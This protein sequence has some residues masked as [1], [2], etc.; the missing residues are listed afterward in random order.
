MGCSVR[1]IEWE[2]GEKYGHV[3]FPSSIIDLKE[4]IA[5]LDSWGVKNDYSF[6]IV[7]YFADK[8]LHLAF[9]VGNEQSY[10]EFMYDVDRS[11]NRGKGPYYLYNS[12]NKKG[13]TPI[14]YMASHAEVSLEKTMPKQDVLNAVY[15]FI[16]HCSFPPYIVLDDSEANEKFVDSNIDV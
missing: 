12:S 15:Y 4:K 11:T 7:V 16:L 8:T 2:F 10:L 13:V 5:E 3:F 1:K 14:Y 9:T 6:L